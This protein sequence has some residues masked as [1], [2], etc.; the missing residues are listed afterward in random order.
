VGEPWT[1][2]A[3]LTLASRQHPSSRLVTRLKRL[4]CHAGLAFLDTGRASGKLTIRDVVEMR[5][6]APCWISVADDIRVEGRLAGEGVKTLRVQKWSPRL[7]RFYGRADV[8]QLISA[9]KRE[10]GLLRLADAEFIVDVG[11]GVG[12]RDG[13]ES[14]VEP[15]VA[16]LR[17]LGVPRLMVGGSRKVTEELHILPLDRQIGQSGTRVNPIILLAIG[18]SG[19][20]Q[21]LNY[22]GTRATIVSFNRDP[23]AP[24]MILNRQQPRPRVF[25]IVGDLLET[26]PAFTKALQAENSE[27]SAR[28]PASLQ[29][30]AVPT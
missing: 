15:L 5:A 28:D 4:E 22:I 17:T 25:G 24:I 3:I 13:Y 11:F 8:Q 16:S 12:N 29:T 23:E 26:V 2:A 27:Q 6:G 19:A 20:P 10:T 21:H 30:T 7:E 14:V 9:L 1:E 18:V